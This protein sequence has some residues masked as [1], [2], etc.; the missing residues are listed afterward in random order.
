MNRTL[1]SGRCWRSRST[2]ARRLQRRDVA[3]AGHHDVRLAALVVA[4]EVP[5]P[6]PARAVEDRLVHRQPVRRGLLAGHDDV[7]VVAAA[8]AVVGHRQERVRVGRQ[9]DPDHVGL[10]VHHVVDE[11]RVLVAEAVVVL[12]PDERAQDVVERGDRPPPRD[13]AGHLQPLRVLV[14]HRVDDVDEGLVAVEEAVPPGQEVA[15]QPALALVL[16][17]DLHHPALGRLVLV[18]RPGSRR[19]TGGPSPRTPR[20]AGWRSSRRARRAGTSRGCGR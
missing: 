1:R 17:E 14:E 12:A 6:D 5:D 8:Q 10:L 19:R 7:H 11:A 2:A 3:A 4:G 13:V 18:R 16:G 15:L 9:V 20:R